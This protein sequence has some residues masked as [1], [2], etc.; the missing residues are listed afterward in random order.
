MEIKANSLKYRDDRSTQETQN[1]SNLAVTVN[2]IQ[3]E[4]YV[5]YHIVISLIWQV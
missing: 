2:V 4:D 5:V 3:F 1:N